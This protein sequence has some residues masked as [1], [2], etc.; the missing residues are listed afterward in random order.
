MM[1]MTMMDMTYHSILIK[2]EV[3]QKKYTF[4]QILPIKV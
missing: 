1:M 3:D 2:T 4:N